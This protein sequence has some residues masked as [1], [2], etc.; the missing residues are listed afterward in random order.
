MLPHPLALWK[1]VL[2]RLLAFLCGAVA[3]I[4]AVWMLAG[5]SGASFDVA[6]AKQGETAGEDA[7]GVAGEDSAPG[8]TVD[9][10]AS[11]D[12]GAIGYDATPCEGPYAHH[13]PIGE[14]VDFNSCLPTG[15][16]DDPGTY[17][18]A[19]VAEQMDH[20]IATTPVTWTWGPQTPVRCDGVSVTP[21]ASG[22][23]NCVS[24]LFITP[25]GDSRT[26]TWCWGGT[27][28]G[29]YAQAG[30]DVAQCPTVGTA[31]NW[32]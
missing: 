18:A 31:V 10:V 13:C 15:N 23:A 11:E 30:S 14:A 9:A 12:G 16:A 24:R 19:L 17:S 5:C 20:A 22:D 3:F 27:V 2:C 8:G 32:W 21:A 7:G 28:A 1:H 29:R 6:E 26:A 25:P 4:A